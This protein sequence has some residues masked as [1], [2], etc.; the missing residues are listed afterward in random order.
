MAPAFTMP[1]RAPL[2]AAPPFHYRG[3]RVVYAWAKARPEGIR[4]ALPPA[5]EPVGDMIQFFV[6]HTPDAGALGS[7]DEG[8][9]VIPC[10][11]GGLIGA[12]VAYEYVTSDDSL[13]VGREIWGYPKKLAEV[14]FSEEKGRIC[15]TVSRRGQVLIDI[16]FEAGG[17]EVA[18]KPA[19]QPRLQVKRIPRADGK[20]FD[21]DQ[22]VRNDLKGA[23]FAETRYGA[24]TVA[25]GRNEDDPLDELGP[26][27]V[28]GGEFAIA[29]FTL[30]YGTVLSDS[31]EA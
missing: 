24:C 27:E 2:Y 10:R 13:C 5:F 30:D 22:I 29:N 23:E 21:M 20:G 31:V 1:D 14:G 25:L 12:H 3:V 8:G 16:G 28:L 7:Y 9:V 15:G 18:D 17:A 11:H 26:I 4:R 6:M 19:M